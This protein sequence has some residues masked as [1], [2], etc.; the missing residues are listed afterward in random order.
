MTATAFTYEI[1][2]GLYGVDGDAAFFTGSSA[3]SAAVPAAYHCAINGRPYMLDLKPDRYQDRFL[4]PLSITAQAQQ[5]DTGS[6]ASEASLARDDVWRR[7]FTSWHHGMGQTWHDASDSDPF[8]FRTSR[9]VD[10]WTK[11]R[12]SLLPSTNVINTPTSAI[13]AL[14]TPGGTAASIRRWYFDGNDNTVYRCSNAPGNGGTVSF[15]TT[16]VTG[17][18]TI[19]ATGN[20]NG[21]WRPI[22][23]DGINVYTI[24]SADGAA[25]A[26]KQITISSSSTF[27][28]GGNAGFPNFIGYAKGRLMVGQTES[29]VRKLYDITSG[30]VGSTI[31]IGDANAVMMDAVEAGSYI[32]LGTKGPVV[33]RV[34]RIAADASTGALTLDGVGLTLPDG[35]QLYSIFGYQNFVFIG[36][37]LGWRCCQVD[38][39]SL[40]MGPLVKDATRVQCWAARGQYVWFG[41][42]QIDSSTSGLGRIDLGTFTDTLLPAYATDITTT[43]ASNVI[44]AIVNPN[45]SVTGDLNRPIV[46]FVLGQKWVETDNAAYVTSGTLNTGYVNFGLTDQKTAVGLEVRN[47]SLVAGSYTM[48]VTNY[49]GG[50]FSTVDTVL[51][52]GAVGQTMTVNNLSGSEHELQLTITGSGTTPPAVTNLTLLVH[53]APKSGEMWQLPLLLYDKVHCLDGCTRSVDIWEELRQLRLL[54]SPSTQPVS[55]QIGDQTFT[56][57]V[58]DYENHPHHGSWDKGSYNSTCLVKLKILTGV[59]A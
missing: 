5:Q 24:S 25:L 39:T 38:G 53:P 11:N 31:T 32:W 34:Y 22:C 1:T 33:S 46:Q 37:N 41:W 49:V 36:S 3:V 56:A 26:V 51:A 4:G 27:F 7:S 19:G 29:G 57:F 47:E 13:C 42:S 52:Q 30:A 18:P 54:R 12:V 8:M 17:N 44:G 2:E 10:V 6:V 45:Q 59:T 9:G 14:S 48:G 23:S 55:F 58:D 15:T 20:P 35:E 16:S 21:P 40:T 50:A 43:D 28:S